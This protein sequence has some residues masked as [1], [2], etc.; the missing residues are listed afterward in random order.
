MA[1]VPYAPHTRE[2]AAQACHP[3]AL[4]NGLDFVKGFAMTAYKLMTEPEH[5]EKIKEEFNREVAGNIVSW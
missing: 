2:F 1:D 3:A 5:L 4:D